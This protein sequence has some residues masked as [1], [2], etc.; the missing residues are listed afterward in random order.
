[1]LKVPPHGVG[2][3]K[4]SAPEKYL[5]SRCDGARP[6]S[7]ILQVAPLRELETLKA[8]RRFVDSQIVEMR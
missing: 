4:L 1:M 5:L 7:R 2:L 3:L 8:F 6:L